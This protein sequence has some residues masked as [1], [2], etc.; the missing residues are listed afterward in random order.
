MR[1]NIN[2]LDEG[3]SNAGSLILTWD[4]QPFSGVAY[5]ISPQ[6]TLWCEQSYKDGVLAGLSKDWYLNEQLKSQTEYKWNRVH[7]RDQGWYENGRPEYDSYYEL[8]IMLHEHRWN[9]TGVLVKSYKVEDNPKRHAD[10]LQEKAI[11]LK[12]GL[13]S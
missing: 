6:G 1:L 7:G 12:H 2:E 3:Y 9:K 4:G 13:I 5:E 10:L 8:G 11:F